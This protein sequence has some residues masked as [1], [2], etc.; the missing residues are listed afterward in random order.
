MITVEDHVTDEPDV[1]NKV[2][3]L[4]EEIRGYALSVAQSR[5][6]ITEALQRCK[7]QQKQ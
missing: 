5:V 1:A 7:S 2:I 3:A 4:F 6:V